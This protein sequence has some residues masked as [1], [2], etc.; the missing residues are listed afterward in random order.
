MA[1]IHE[2]IIVIKMS[3]LVKSDAQCIS[4]IA[5]DDIVAALAE[6]AEQLAGAGVVVEVEKA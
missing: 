2:E 5:T 1:Q 4:S 3:R 6:V